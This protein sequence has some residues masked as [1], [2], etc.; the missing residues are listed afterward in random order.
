MRGSGR[1]VDVTRV[2]SSIPTRDLEVLDANG[3]ES[4]EH[5]TEDER[6]GHKEY[7][8]G[9]RLLNRGRGGIDYRDYRCVI[10]FLNS[11]R[12]VFAL[13]REIQLLANLNLPPETTFVE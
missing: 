6:Y 3:P 1:L 10:D 11:C 4:A 7:S 5:A 8:F 12:F 9:F 13:E 2:H